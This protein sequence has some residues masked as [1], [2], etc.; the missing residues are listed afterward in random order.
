[1]RTVQRWEN[2]GLPV[3]RVNKSPRSP[4]VADSDELDAWILHRLKLPDGAPENLLEN[5]QRA[6]ELH[7]ATERNRKQFQLQVQ[8]FKKNVAKYIAR[9]RRL[10]KKGL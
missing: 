4:V 6:Q 5:R 9:P 8:E 3:K 10:P 2:S 1:M 7:L